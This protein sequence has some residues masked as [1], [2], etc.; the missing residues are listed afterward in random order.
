MS[1]KIMTEEAKEERKSRKP[2]F[3]IAR[4][5]L[6]ASVG[7]ISIAQDEIEDFVNKLIERG[8]IAEQ[9]GRKLISEI[10]DKRK[11]RVHKAEDE[12]GRRVE[13]VLDRLNVPTKAD[14]DS[15]SKQVS[16]LSKKVEEL[17]KNQA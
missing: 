11:Q 3:S 4:K 8:E 12:I 2:M 9:D 15:L 7:A 13:V 16:A 14:I 1:L 5:L 10:V 6:L 17:K